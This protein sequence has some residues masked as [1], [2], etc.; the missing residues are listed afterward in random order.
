MSQYPNAAE[1]VKKI[2]ISQLIFIAALILAAIPL[3]GTIGR[4]LKIVACVIYLMG[5]KKAGEDG[6]G[7][8]KAFT[9]EIVNIVF[10]LVIVIVSLIPLI[11]GIL[12]TVLGI[13]TSIIDL[14]VLNTVITTTGGLLRNVGATDIAENGQSVWTMYIICTV[15]SIIC[16]LLSVIPL[17]NILAGIVAF[18]VTIVLLVALIRYIIFLNKAATALGA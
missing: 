15:I 2:Y 13:I 1:G 11:G 18:I 17:I 3:L 8:N 9:Y 7:Y 4:I 14:L 12:G 16:S 10:V 6:D 5:L